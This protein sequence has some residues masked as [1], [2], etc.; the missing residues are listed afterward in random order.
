MALRADTVAG[1]AIAKKFSVGHPYRKE[2]K[3]HTRS[4]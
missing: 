3:I 4:N 2:K 1:T